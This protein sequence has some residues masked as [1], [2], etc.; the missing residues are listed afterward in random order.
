MVKSRKFAHQKITPS[1]MQHTMPQAKLYIP[2]AIKTQIN[3]VL[4]RFLADWA[5][6]ALLKISATFE[7]FFHYFMC[8]TSTK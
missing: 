8:K 4:F 5:V 7:C 6:R 2:S 1:M 3:L